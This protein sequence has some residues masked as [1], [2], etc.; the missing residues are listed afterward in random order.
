MSH[1]F[2]YLCF[3][4]KVEEAFN[5]RNEFR[6]ERQNF[7]PKLTAETFFSQTK[8]Q[9]SFKINL[10]ILSCDSVTCTP[11]LVCVCVCVCV[12]VERRLPG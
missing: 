7:K 6:T 4:R 8:V 12:C 5:M 1:D 3:V 11:G 9:K 2:L 10:D